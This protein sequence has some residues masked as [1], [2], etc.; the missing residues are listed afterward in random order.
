[1][2]A[3]DINPRQHFNEQG[4]RELKEEFCEGACAS[5][6][7]KES[8]VAEVCQYYKIESLGGGALQERC[9]NPEFNK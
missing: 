2:T 4:N 3:M 5:G 9:Y 7:T 6:G 8:M 1:M